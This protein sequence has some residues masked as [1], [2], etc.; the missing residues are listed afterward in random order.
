MALVFVL[1]GCSESSVASLQGRWDGE[2]RCPGSLRELSIAFDISG[3]SIGGEAFITTSAVRVEFDVTG[4]QVL[5]QRY[6]RCLDD[7]CSSDKAC[8]SRHDGVAF[9]NEGKVV[10]EGSDEA[11]ALRARLDA[12]YG[13]GC[14]VA[15]PIGTPREQET[16]SR[17][18]NLGFCEPCLQ[19]QR[20]RRVLVTLEGPTGGAARP[21]LDLSRDGE[22]RLSGTIRNYCDDVSQAEPHVEL[23]R[24]ER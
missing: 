12:R 20:Y 4:Q 18:S 13:K 9:P 21:E 15:V 14:P 7:S 10:K 3:E 1:A 16:S 19:Q 2:I 5:C 23:E 17:C 11:K 6:V 24:E 8:A 22:T